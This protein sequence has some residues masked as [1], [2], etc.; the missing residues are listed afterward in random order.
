MALRTPPSW[1]QNGSHPAENDRLSMQ[2]VI[3]TSGIIA[4]ASLAVTQPA[5]PGLAVQ[6]APAWG[7]LFGNFKTK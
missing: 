3:A 7:P 4:T 1:L 6:V 2:A 5:A